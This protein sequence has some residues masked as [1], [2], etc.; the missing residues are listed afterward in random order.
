M[1]KEMVFIRP[2]KAS[3]LPDTA[4]ASVTG[5][6]AASR[7]ARVP[8]VEMSSQPW[9]ASARASSTTPVLSVTESRARRMGTRPSGSAIGVTSAP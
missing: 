2:P 5:R 4:A 1:A 3:G 9:A 6:P 7:A 8:P